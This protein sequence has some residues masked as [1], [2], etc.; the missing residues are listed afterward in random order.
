[1]TPGSVAVVL[2]GAGRLA[3]FVANALAIRG[4]RVVH[5]T[6]GPHADDGLADVDVRHSRWWQPATW[7]AALAGI[8][9]PVEDVAAV[10]N[11]VAG[12]ERSHADS[13]RTGVGA[14]RS[15]V[16]LTEAAASTGRPVRSLHVGSAA[17]YQAGKTSAYACGKA[18]AR[19]EALARRVTMILTL[20]VVP[21]PAG[22]HHDALLRRCA[23]MIPEL[24]ALPVAAT[25]STT[26]G[27][28]IV[29]LLGT[30]WARNSGHS[31]TAEIMLAAEP[32]PLGQLLAADSSLHWYSGP[33]LSCL[34]WLP[35]LSRAPRAARLF[36]CARLAREGGQA[37]SHYLV[38][39]FPG[40]E[41]HSSHGD[42]WRLVEYEGGAGTTYWLFPPV[43]STR[44]PST[45]ARRAS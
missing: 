31:P 45:G 34:A 8:G 13:A 25:P 29:F 24:A 14:I 35:K 7:S 40:Q 27:D 6:R 10:V 21:R 15:M 16:A 41:P 36:S 18:A 23:A 33:L 44:A 20:G 32:V 4:F 9:C 2:G 38:N 30:E 37:R 1:M 3:P 28:A 5:I 22:D 42:G 43:R 17:Q 19:T 12:R 11:L 39:V 26:A